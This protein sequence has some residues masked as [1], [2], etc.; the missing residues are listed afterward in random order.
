M[1]IH[2][3]NA[4]SLGN[5]IVEGTHRPFRALAC[6]LGSIYRDFD[7]VEEFAEK[8]F[9]APDLPRPLAVRHA[10]PVG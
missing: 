9:S 5:L 1:T 7:F 8:T 10:L 4:Q 2:I 6:P 3:T